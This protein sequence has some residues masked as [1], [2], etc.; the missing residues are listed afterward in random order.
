MRRG[1][2]RPLNPD[3]ILPVKTRVCNLL[4]AFFYT[5]QNMSNKYMSL[6]GFEFHHIFYY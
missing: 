2:N 5:N 3:C 6:V 4:R 1:E